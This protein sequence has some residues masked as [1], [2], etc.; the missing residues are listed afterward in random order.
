M[1]TDVGTASEVLSTAVV[2]TCTR[3]PNNSRR[4]QWSPCFSGSLT[5]SSCKT[6]TFRP[7]ILRPSKVPDSAMNLGP[8]VFTVLVATLGALGVVTVV[9]VVLVVLARLLVEVVVVVWEERPLR[10]I[11][12]AAAAPVAVAAAVVPARPAPFELSRLASL[13]DSNLST[14]VPDIIPSRDLL[15]SSSSMFCF[16]ERSPL[17]LALVEVQVTC[18]RSEFRLYP[19]IF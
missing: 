16:T 15:N 17:P 6:A 14:S 8:P 18:E 12:P 5:T 10:V 7:P 1:T 9:V 4:K 11:A 3:S 13:S 19:Q 2:T